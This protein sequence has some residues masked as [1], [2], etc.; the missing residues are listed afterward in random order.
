MLFSVPGLIEQKLVTLL[1]S[2]NHKIM[3]IHLAEK[4][5]KKKYLYRFSCILALS[6]HWG[7]STFT[8]SMAMKHFCLTYNLLM[9]QKP[10]CQ[11]GLWEFNVISEQYFLHYAQ[12]WK[13]MSIYSSFPEVEYFQPF[14]K[15]QRCLLTEYEFIKD[16][17]EDIMAFYSFYLYSCHIRVG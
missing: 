15:G 10:I 6:L 12:W 14:L 8:L 4:Y 17:L 7:S 16:N 3:S 9:G 2:L 13:Q 1:H 5:E 11:S